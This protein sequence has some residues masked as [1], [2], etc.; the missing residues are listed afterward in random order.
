MTK[1]ELVIEGTKAVEP[2][3]AAT[4]RKRCS[5]SKTLLAVGGL[6]VVQTRDG[7]LR[8]HLYVS[9]RGIYLVVL[10]SDVHKDSEEQHGG[11]KSRYEGCDD[12]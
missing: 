6:R 5:A 8:D 4:A 2:G 7:L 11:K 10:V 9:A 3:I 12:G 1:N